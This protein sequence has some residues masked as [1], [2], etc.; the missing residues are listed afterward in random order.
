MPICL[1][2]L[3]SP[4]LIIEPNKIT[5]STLP[6]H[7]PHKR[8]NTAFVE[9]VETVETAQNL[10]W[11]TH[12]IVWG[13]FQDNHSVQTKSFD[14][15]RGWD[16]AFSDPWESDERDNRWTYGTADEGYCW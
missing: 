11:G 5:N 4:N 7:I 3:K 16:S 2:A 6:R 12:T 13:S 8:W 14:E 10:H 9:T 1:R 15:A